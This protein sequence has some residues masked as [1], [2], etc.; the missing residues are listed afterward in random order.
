MAPTGQNLTLYGWLPK[1]ISPSWTHI[2]TGSD[3]EYSD[4]EE[5]A[6]RYTFAPDLAT[7]ADLVNYL[8]SVGKWEGIAPGLKGTLLGL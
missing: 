6:L 4:V 2:E 1:A 7:G 3:D 8:K 5:N